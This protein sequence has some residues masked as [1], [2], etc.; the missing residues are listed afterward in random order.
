VKTKHD[1]Q[2]GLVKS[3]QKLEKIGVKSSAVLP[4]EL[5]SLEDDTPVLLE[6][7]EV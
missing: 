1:G 7:V 5:A 3:L 2:Q 4:K 6:M